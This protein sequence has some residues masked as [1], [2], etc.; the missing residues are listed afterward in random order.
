MVIIKVKKVNSKDLI[1]IPKFAYATDACA[2]VQANTKAIIKPGEFKIVSTGLKFEI[3]KGWEIQIR[4]RSGLTAKFGIF[5]LN[6]PG[7]ID[8]QYRGECKIVLM[9]SGQK[10]YVINRG[11]RIAQLAVKKVYDVIFT[12][13]DVINATD[14]GEKGFGSSGIK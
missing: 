7:T 9:N 6:S 1:D 3:P 11:D 12:E 4:S 13:V 14:R 2:D 10:P 8:Q 5:V